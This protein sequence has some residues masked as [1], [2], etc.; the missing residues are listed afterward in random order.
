MD[1]EIEAPFHRWFS[2]D[3]YLQKA[4]L[5]HWLATNIEMIGLADPEAKKGVSEKP[6]ENEILV[7]SVGDANDV[8]G[9]ES[10]PRK[11]GR[12]GKRKA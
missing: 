6:V 3:G 9:S 5:H 1:E 10:S 11:S 8:G 4:Y 7:D 2:G 12:K